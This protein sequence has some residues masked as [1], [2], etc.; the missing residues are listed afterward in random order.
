MSFDRKLVRSNR[1]SAVCASVALFSEAATLICYRVAAL[2]RGCP[3]RLLVLGCRDGLVVRELASVLPGGSSVVQCDVSFD[4]LAGVKEGHLVVADDEA[5]PFKEASFDFIV[6]NLSFHNVNGLVE[7][8]AK[9]HS[10]LAENGILIAATF[11][12][13]TLYE[14]KKALM[15][16][17]AEKMRVVPR[18]QPFYTTSDMLAWLQLCGFSGLVADVHTIGISYSSFYDLFHDLKNMGEGNTLRRVYEPISRSDIEKAWNLYKRSI[19]MDG[20]TSAP[21]QFE[22]V[23][24]KG[25][26]QVFKR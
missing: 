23:M 26:K 25:N 15:S 20:A 4:V 21:V 24:L 6:S 5:L 14:V 18:I 22:I 11:G 7:V 1:A 12:N 16:A 19:G 10:C 9:I 13:G 8:F 17:E 2:L 3:V